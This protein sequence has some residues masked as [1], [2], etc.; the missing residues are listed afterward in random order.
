MAVSAGDLVIINLACVQVHTRGAPL[1]VRTSNIP[2]KGDYVYIDDDIGYVKVLSSMH[3]L[4]KMVPTR[5]KE[6]SG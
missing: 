2:R 3:G 6:G 1:E 5:H 4:A